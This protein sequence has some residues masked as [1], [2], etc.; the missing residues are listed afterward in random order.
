MNKLVKTLAVGAMLASSSAY[1]VSIAVCA[2][3]VSQR[4]IKSTQRLQSRNLWRYNEGYDGISN[5]EYKRCRFGSDG[6]VD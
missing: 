5:K 2:G 6:D 3:C 4:N 1:A